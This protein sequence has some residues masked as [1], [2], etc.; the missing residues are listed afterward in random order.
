MIQPGDALRGRYRIVR[1]LG[2][3]GMADV[4]LAFDQKRYVQVAIKVMRED[5]AE[6]PDF[7][8]R[9]A[10]EARALAW[11]DH[12]NIVRFYSFEREGLLAFLVMD[13]VDGLTLRTEL[14]RRQGP[15]T[16]SETTSVLRDIGSALFYAHNEGVIHRDLKPGNIMLARDGR[17]L[18]TDFGIAKA[19]ESATVTTMAAGT[20]A[21]M[22]P[23]QILGQPLDVRTDIY[24]LGVM[25][26]LMVTGRRLFTGEEPGLTG[27]GAMAR[28]REAHLRLQPPDPRRFNPDLPPDAAHVILRSLAK[29]PQ[30][31]WPDM[32]QL[33]NT[34]NSAMADRIT[35]EAPLGWQQA[36]SRAA[37]AFPIRRH[38]TPQ[39]PPAPPPHRLSPSASSPGKPRLAWF[40]VGAILFIAALIF[41][42]LM[43]AGRH[44]ATPLPADTPVPIAETPR[45]VI[46]TTD[47]ALTPHPTPQPTQPGTNKIAVTQTAVAKETETAVLV[48]TRVAA[49]SQVMN[50]SA[51]AT[52]EAQV[53]T[54]ATATYQ[55]TQTAEAQQAQD[56]VA[57]TN[58][59]Q[60]YGD[61]KVQ[62]MTYLDSNALA[63]VLIDPVL[64][65]K[66][67]VICWLR[68]NDAYYTYED[69]SVDIV[70]IIFKNSDDATVYAWLGEHITIVKGG[71]VDDW[72]YDR[73][74]AVYHL[75]KINDRWMIDCLNALE[76]D[77]DFSPHCEVKFA[78]ENPCLQ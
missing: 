42:L 74:K 49:T 34:W 5:L 26:F 9:F 50:D 45:P 52:A 35:P 67:Q 57:I 25:L 6:D 15:L 31:R 19:L 22:S 58:A 66:R 36:T 69:R 62:G 4:Y 7:V 29:Q 10:R 53:Q 24:S 37:S 77:E 16:L 8:Q 68:K 20:P 2:R 71:K 61:I 27:T 78:S 11:L 48:A 38:P 60:R 54:Q 76:D 14:A 40:A 1:L 41:L 12:P 47:I 28:M 64:E 65:Q 73:Y 51:T 18:L 59:I 43:R 17:A 46:A 56:R 23:E 13:F 70:D 39:P 21:Y 55:A 75:R 30:Q 32:K 44:A 63:E 33:V 3:G 72:G